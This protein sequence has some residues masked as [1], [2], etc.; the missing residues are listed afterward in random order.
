M[1][2]CARDCQGLNSHSFR[3]IGDGHQPNSGGLYTQYRD[4]LLPKKEPI[5]GSGIQQ[6]SWDPTKVMGSNTGMNGL[7]MSAWVL[8]PDTGWDFCRN[9]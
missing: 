9:F 3:I 1:I 2:I 6:R 7:C 4:S 8:L 5:L